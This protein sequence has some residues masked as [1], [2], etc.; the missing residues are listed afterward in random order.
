MFSLEAALAA[1]AEV[2]WRPVGE[3]GE[4]D[5][6]LLLVLLILILMCLYVI[7]TE[8][9]AHAKAENDLGLRSE[10]STAYTMMP[11]QTPS[12]PASAPQ[13]VTQASD[14]ITVLVPEPSDT[15]GPTIGLYEV[16]IE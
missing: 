4:L 10:L 1:S 11:G 9:E 7:I 12:A 8:R 3:L 16:E 5:L 13:L 6:L 15:G 14:H 2:I